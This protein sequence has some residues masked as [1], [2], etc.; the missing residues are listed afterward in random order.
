MPDPAAEWPEI[1]AWR[2]ATRQALGAARTAVGAAER[3]RVQGHVGQLLARLL[4]GRIAAVAP[5][6]PG[7]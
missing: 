6:R 2:K 5:D 3:E 7:L 4:G 1:R